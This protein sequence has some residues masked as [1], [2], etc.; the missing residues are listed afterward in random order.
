MMQSLTKERRL[1]IL[2]RGI[3]RVGQDKL[4]VMVRDISRGGL[5]MCVPPGHEARFTVGAAFDIACQLPRASSP[6]RLSA[7]VTWSRRGTDHRGEDALLVGAAFERLDERARAGL[8]KFVLE[9]FET[10]LVVDP[11][12]ASRKTAKQALEAQYDVIEADRGALA[13][14][15]LDEREVA[16]I[17]VAASMPD[18]DAKDFLRD[19][20]HRYPGCRAVR[21]VITSPEDAPLLEEVSRLHRIFYFLRRPVQ[22]KELRDVVRG[23]VAQY[24]ENA[25]RDPESELSTE[26]AEFSHRVLEA[27]RR[28]SAQGELY[29]AGRIAIDAVA[30]L[31]EADRSAYYV[32]DPISETLWSGGK[33]RGESNRSAIAGLA[34][35]VARTGASV[36]VERA[37]MDTRFVASVDDPEA[38]GG[39][40][41]MAVPLL[42]LDRRALGVLIAVRNASRPTF[43]ADDLERFVT[44]AS[45]F[46]PA[47]G[48]MALQ[49]QIEE[50]FAQKRRSEDGA[51]PFRRLALEAN[52]ASGYELARPLKLSPRWVGRAYWLLV[53]VTAAALLFLVLGKMPEY[54]MG[55]AVVRIEGR[56]DITAVEPGIVA[57][58]AVQPGQRV[59]AKQVLVRLHD[60]KEALD[61]D[62]IRNEFELQL[63]K[64]LRNPGDIATRETLARLRTERDFALAKLEGRAITAP[65]AGIVNDVRIRA[66]QSLTPGDPILSLT[67]AQAEP[68]II[69]LIPG[70][71]RPMLR[72][73]QTVRLEVSGFRYAYANLEL[74]TIGDEVV[75]PLEARRYLGKEIGDAVQLGGP[76]VLVR[77]RLPSR[78]F[79]A[80]GKLYNYHDGMLATAEVRV[81]TQRILARLVPALQALPWFSSF[82]SEAFDES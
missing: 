59:A 40:R 27:T 2:C 65:H 23:A 11:D 66:G 78:S 24:W 18:G 81:R 51:S 37:E 42:S 70:Q 44:L 30:E 9:F 34:G 57:A 36:T 61:L 71:F 26:S 48:Q 14:R 73:G 45:N 58:V 76:V 7:K 41:M 63:V 52:A 15:I 35:Y 31:I 50:V 17:V 54:A 16:V 32:Y 67:G 47:F 80:D 1:I 77:A 22:P 60:V 79:S 69:A 62:R 20:T 28:L 53:A 75:G 39:E 21:M 25:R 5:K 72:A 82:W 3:A 33:A 43:D 46:A 10:V 38:A 68:S 49:T 8:E 29:A 64:S 74:E 13:L 55:P 12:A 19:V 6:S 4:P 56:T